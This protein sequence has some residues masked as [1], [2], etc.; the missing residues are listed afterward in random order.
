[1]QKVTPSA[2]KILFVV[3]NA[4]NGAGEVKT[5]KGFCYLGHR[6]YTSG[7]REAAVTAKTRVRWRKFRE[8]EEILFGKRF[9][10]QIKGNEIMLYKSKTWCLKNDVK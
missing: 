3:N 7:G 8:C 10:L 1:M 2:A 5:V 4:I 6:L 9:S